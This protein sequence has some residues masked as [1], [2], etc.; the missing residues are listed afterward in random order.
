MLPTS[1]LIP[2]QP[3]EQR[4]VSPFD[5]KR[6]RADFPM[7]QGNLVYLDSGATSLKPQQVID[8]EAEFYAK[9]YGTVRRGIYKLS[10]EATRMYEGVREKARAF[11]NAKDVTEIVFTRG[12]TE[13]INL[14][15]QTFGRT[16][17]K[18]G[19]RILV[20][21]MEHHANIVSWQLVAE[22]VGAKL[23]AIPIDDTGELRMDAFAAMLDERV[24]IVAIAHMSNVLGTVNP[25]R[26]I[27]AKAH[28]V[29]AKVLLDGAQSAAHMPVDV[30]D[31][32]ADFFVFSSHKMCGPTGAG[33][34]YGRRALLD[35]MPPW[36]GGGDM[37]ATV[38][39]DKTTFE[40]PPYRFE[41]GTPPIAQIIG[42]GAAIDYV[43]AI[44]R[45][46]IADH[47]HALL[48][49]ADEKLKGIDGF[50]VFG[51][52]KTKGGIISF[53]IGNLAPYDIGT[54]LDEQNIAVRVGHHCAQPLMKRL[55]VASTARASFG[56]YTSE[57]DIDALADGLARA[58]RI[59]A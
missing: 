20:S 35:T 43:N 55:G 40:E 33:V 4:G 6:I 28:A 45:D 58:Q 16:S 27:I 18:A 52:S 25:A 41:A 34:L 44:G 30:Q 32:D 26:E 37:I 59:L 24:K 3:V 2:P 12:S 38:S 53:A 11:V 29:G 57:A 1:C 56:V 39:F 5:L 50:R 42:L 17:L 46:V 8:A 47:E 49:Y 15:A 14:V 13:A 22:Q 21:E 7:L 48:A 19:D 51:T 36:Q 10:Q 23:E 31:L 9:H 54:L